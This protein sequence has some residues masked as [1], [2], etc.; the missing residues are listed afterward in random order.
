LFG[1]GI[2]QPGG[3]GF[4]RNAWDRGLPIHGIYG[5]SELQALLSVQPATLPVPERV[6][7]GGRLVSNEARARARDS[8]TG[9]VLPPG[10]VGELEIK[11]ARSAFTGYL[12]DPSATT[13]AIDEDGYFRTGDLGYVRDDGT[14]VFETRLGDVMRIGGFLVSPIEIEDVL[15][16]ISGVV[17]AQ[18]VSVTIGGK[19][20]PVAFVIVD[21]NATPTAEA[22][23]LQAGKAMASFK[24]PARVWFVDRFPVTESANGTKIQHS[25]LREMALERLAE[26]MAPPVS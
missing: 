12:D 7:A 4:A 23:R 6:K 19:N 21:R 25:K 18:V 26:E 8:Q 3:Q 2:F 15:E 13:A 16:G 10:G 9:A 5:S 11:S 1:Y 22:I 17:D 20:Q 14:F 24:V